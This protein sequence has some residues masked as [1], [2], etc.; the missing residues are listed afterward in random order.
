[1]YRRLISI[2]IITLLRSDVIIVTTPALLDTI[3]AS[4]PTCFAFNSWWLSLDPDC[5]AINSLAYNF[6][7]TLWLNS[8]SKLFKSQV[9]FCS[10]SYK[11]LTTIPWLKFKCCETQLN[12]ASQNNPK[13][14]I[15]IK[16]NQLTVCYPV[17][18]LVN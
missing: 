8:H 3:K 11:K 10:K 16:N 14:F 6:S 12:S 13:T 2:R 1:M 7:Y 18:F 9:I 15:K 4:T 5:L 17:K